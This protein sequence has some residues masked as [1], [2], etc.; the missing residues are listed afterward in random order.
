M[1]RGDR[2]CAVAYGCFFLFFFYGPRPKTI[3]H[4]L[5]EVY[6]PPL[7]TCRVRNTVGAYESLEYNGYNK[8]AVLGSGP[9]IKLSQKP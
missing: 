5:T 6:L 2:L 9:F 1:L 7:T 4:I 3:L 8:R